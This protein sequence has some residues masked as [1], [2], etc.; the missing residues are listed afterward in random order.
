MYIKYN[1]S[2]LTIHT[3][4]VLVKLSIRSN[5]RLSKTVCTNVREQKCVCESSFVDRFQIVLVGY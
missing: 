2:F 1:L 3:F 4:L 5:I